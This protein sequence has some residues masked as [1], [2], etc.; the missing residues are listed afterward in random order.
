MGV[1]PAP[2]W[3]GFK[4][5]RRFRHDVYLGGSQR[6][7]KL[8]RLSAAGHTDGLPSDHCGLHYPYWPTAWADTAALQAA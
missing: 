4:Y 1:D 3:A 7:L 6:R 5:S 8:P 2:S